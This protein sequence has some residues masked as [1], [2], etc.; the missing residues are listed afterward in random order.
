[1]VAKQGG[2]GGSGKKPRKTNRRR[3]Q[4]TSSGKTKKLARDRGR[5]TSGGNEGLPPQRGR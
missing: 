3:T 5:R 4:T 2:E 1:M